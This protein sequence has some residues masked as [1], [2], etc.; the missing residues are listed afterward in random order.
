MRGGE[1]GGG[2]PKTAILHLGERENRNTAY[3]VAVVKTT[4]PP[5]K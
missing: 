1:G 5:F 3:K 4:D 2:G